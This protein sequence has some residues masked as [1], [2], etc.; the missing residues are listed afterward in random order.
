MLTKSQI[1][2]LSRLEDDYSH[3]DSDEDL[4][5]MLKLIDSPI[6]LHFLPSLLNWDSGW[7]NEI[8]HWVLEHPL[9]DAGTA[10]YI[11]WLSEPDWFYTNKAAGEIPKWAE[12]GYALFKKCEGLYLADKFSQGAIRFNPRD[13]R[14]LPKDPSRD[15]DIEC[16]IPEKLKVATP[17]EE[18]PDYWD[19]KAALDENAI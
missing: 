19:A 13:G 17:G 14:Y 1:R 9:C 16:M 7:T 15:S 6:Q 5:G 3:I 12:D 8:M 10:L 11:Y 2:L 18:V 4:W